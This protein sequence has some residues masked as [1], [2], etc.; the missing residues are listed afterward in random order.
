MTSK[1]IIPF[2]RA[3]LR[4]ERII[5]HVVESAFE[6]GGENGLVVDHV[7]LAL[8]GLVVPQAVRV[9]GQTRF[10]SLLYKELRVQQILLLQLQ[11]LCPRS[12]DIV[13]GYDV[14]GLVILEEI[15]VEMLV[16]PH[17]LEAE[18]EGEAGLNL[19]DL[20]NVQQLQP[21]PHLRSL[22]TGL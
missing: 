12:P 20:R 9:V 17:E 5:L 22:Q 6:L 16:P 10:A 2:E 18:G 1:L 13:V 7:V 11:Q 15:E 19:A 3:V 14:F 4:P 21:R 8:V